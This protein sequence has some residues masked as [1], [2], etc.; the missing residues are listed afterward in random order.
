MMNVV[1]KLDLPILDSQLR[2]ALEQLTEPKY[3][4]CLEGKNPDTIEGTETLALCFMTVEGPVALLLA[5]FI[6]VLRIAEIH[7]LYVLEKD[8]LKHIGTAL[9]TEIS[10]LLTERKC[11]AASLVYTKETDT[12]PILEHIL[13]KL[14]WEEPQPFSTQCL[15]HNSFNAPWL[16]K[17]YP[18]PEGFEIFPWRE[19]KEEERQELLLKHSK[20]AFPYNI[21]PFGSDEQLI[22]YSNSFGLRYK[23]SVIGWMI[24]HRTAQDTIRYSALYID[25]QWQHKGPA[26]RLLCDAIIIQTE[27]E[28]PWSIFE[29]NL[30]Q[31]N[32]DWLK[33]VEQ[34]L[35]PYAQSVTHTY[36]S[37]KKL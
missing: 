14:G 15:L 27:S 30:H 19:L 17:P 6:P 25:P 4:C 5:T 12:A 8:R 23:N 32:S 11:L 9:L 34:R 16:K 1:V 13:K 26:M 22:E 36:Q 7:S 18:L 35:F 10:K 21:S 2:T 33:F 28:I 37:W 24:T 31:S 20:K 29:V 3:R